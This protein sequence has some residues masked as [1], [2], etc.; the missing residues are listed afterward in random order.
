M[1]IIYISL[2]NNEYSF[3]DIDKEDNYIYDMGYVGLQ[4]LEQYNKKSVLF[5][6]TV[7]E[8][9][10][11]QEDNHKIM[12][13]DQFNYNDDEIKKSWAATASHY[14]F[15]ALERKFRQYPQYIDKLLETNFDYLIYKSDD[16]FLGNGKDEDGLNLYGTCLM[17]L[18]DYFKDEKEHK[19]FS[20]QQTNTNEDDI[21]DIPLE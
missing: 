6:K 11:E 5:A 10:E 16:P 4:G 13:K 15:S 21:L 17:R 7:R 12:C 1:K 2:D 3:L 8:V 19:A 18:R 9:F 20:N 14:L